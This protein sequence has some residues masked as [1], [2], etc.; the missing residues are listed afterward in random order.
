[1]KGPI[2]GLASHSTRTSAIRPHQSVAKVKGARGDLCELLLEGVLSMMKTKLLVAITTAL[3]VSISS[4]ELIQRDWLVASD[5]LLTEDTETGL[6]WMDLTATRNLKISD[7][8]DRFDD[9]FFGFRYATNSEISTLWFHAGISPTFPFSSRI[10]REAIDL[11]NLLG[12]WI[13]TSAPYRWG[14]VGFSDGEIIHGRFRDYVQQPF[15]E[16][17]IPSNTAIASFSRHERDDIRSLDWGHWLV[18][19]AIQMSVSEP[20]ILALIFASLIASGVGLPPV[21]KGVVRGAS[22]D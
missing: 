19:D 10:A 5:G 3:W 15:I 22:L 6:L 7:V 12:S 2:K 17:D 14:I 21:V 16:Y 8:V 9:S 1:M 11:G 4:A 20:S 18:T 13:F